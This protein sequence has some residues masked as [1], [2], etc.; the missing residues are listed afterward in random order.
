MVYPHENGAIYACK[1]MQVAEIAAFTINDRVR[2]NINM[3]HCLLDH[4]NEDSVQKTEREL[5]W[6]L[7]HTLQT[8]KHCPK[9][10][11]RQN[12]VLKESIIDNSSKN[13]HTR[14]FLDLSKVTVKYEE[15]WRTRQSIVITARLWWAKPW[16]RNGAT[17]P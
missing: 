17:S 12:N 3:A 5:G 1:F 8:C 4:W 9:S 11:T 2:L 6:V 14:L 13:R 15:T 7:T 10:K 16:E